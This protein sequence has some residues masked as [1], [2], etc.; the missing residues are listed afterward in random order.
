MSTAQLTN[1]QV[2]WPV[3]NGETIDI[4]ALKARGFSVIQNTF[5][6]VD[7]P[8]VINGFEA[9]IPVPMPLYEIRRRNLL[10]AM[11]AKGGYTTIKLTKP[12]VTVVGEARAHPADHYC[13]GVG[14]KLAVTKAVNELVKQGKLGKRKV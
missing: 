14:T 9:M 11:R 4:A 1:N 7:M 12:G 3:V 10:D 13:K 6:E 2:N 8:Y 5:R